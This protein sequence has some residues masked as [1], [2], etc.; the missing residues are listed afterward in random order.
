VLRPSLPMQP[1]F[2]SVLSLSSLSYYLCFLAF[3]SH[4]TIHG[5]ALRTDY[6]ARRREC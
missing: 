1:S 3:V 6:A 4:S 5:S 2:P